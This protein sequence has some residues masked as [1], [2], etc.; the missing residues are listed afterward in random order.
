MTH[1]TEFCVHICSIIRTTLY[2]VVCCHL[3]HPQVKWKFTDITHSQTL[4]A[5]L[6]Q[7][8]PGSVKEGGVI[9]HVKLLDES[10]GQP[11]DIG[12][13][14]TIL[15]SST[16][17]TKVSLHSLL[18]SVECVHVHLLLYMYVTKIVCVSVNKVFLLSCF[19][20]V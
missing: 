5:E 18:F 15:A 20:F 1:V 17:Q 2:L 14:I 8:L 7:K 4:S 3:S 19:F 13:T 11:F 10:S 9:H 12:A 16:G 6:I